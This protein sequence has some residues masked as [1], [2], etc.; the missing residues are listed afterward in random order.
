MATSAPISAHPRAAS[1]PIPLGP[2]APVTTTTFP[3]REKRSWRELALGI[4][5]MMMALVVSC[6]CG[7][8]DGMELFMKKEDKKEGSSSKEV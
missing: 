8:C 6:R 5:I 7:K 4:S 3:L 2:E 1:I